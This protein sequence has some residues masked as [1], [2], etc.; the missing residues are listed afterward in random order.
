MPETPPPPLPLLQRV[1]PELQPG[2][3]PDVLVVGP[4]LPSDWMLALEQLGCRVV[5]VTEPDL[6]QVAL[7]TAWFRAVF[8]A[9]SILEEG[10]GVRLVRQLVDRPELADRCRRATLV[11]RPLEGDTQ[12]A[13]FRRG[14]LWLGELSEISLDQ[15]V[16]GP[17][18]VTAI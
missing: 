3:R 1:A 17:W 4:P 14:E 18:P 10:D 15:L 2:Q 8:V 13:A 9:P 12:L 7:Y 6:V 16:V 5:H 11:L